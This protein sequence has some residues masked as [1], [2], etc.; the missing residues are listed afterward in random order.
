M[1]RSKLFNFK[2]GLT[3]SSQRRKERQKKVKILN[4]G[5]KAFEVFYLK[6]IDSLC[7]SSETPIC[8]ACRLDVIHFWLCD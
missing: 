5:V 4:T 8:G 7:V 2:I 6:T 3:Q 1:F